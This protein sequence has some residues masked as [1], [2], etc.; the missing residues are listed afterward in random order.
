MTDI[1]ELQI[2]RS[3]PRIVTDAWALAGSRRLD[4][5]RITNRQLL[6]RFAGLC[7]SYA[8]T[9]APLRTAFTA[10]ANANASLQPGRS[11]H[12]MGHEAQSTQW[13]KPR[14]GLPPACAAASRRSFRP[15]HGTQQFRTCH[16]SGNTD[17][18]A[19]QSTD[20]EANLAFHKPA[21]TCKVMPWLIYLPHSPHTNTFCQRHAHFY[22]RGFILH[23][24]AT[25]TATLCRFAGFDAAPC[26]PTPLPGHLPVDCSCRQTIRVLRD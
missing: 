15:S 24:Q 16:E 5:H 9:H 8:H 18:E 22:V 11:K 7:C 10:N 17:V 2:Y 12:S 4:I 23:P 3:S 1:P 20:G 25:G 6:R 14:L 21:S 19:A 26:L 13:A